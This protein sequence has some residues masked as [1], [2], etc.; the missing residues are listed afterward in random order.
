MNFLSWSPWIGIS[1]KE[2]PANVVKRR[3]RWRR[4][5]KVFGNR[6]INSQTRRNIEAI[7]RIFRVSCWREL[8]YHVN[9]AGVPC[10]WYVDLGKTDPKPIFS[11]Y[12]VGKSS[13]QEFNFL[14]NSGYH[15]SAPFEA[16]LFREPHAGL[17]VDDFSRIQLA[18]D[19]VFVDEHDAL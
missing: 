17:K 16:N 12:Q 9:R 8:K 10:I 2:R 7:E 5:D 4:L 14:S 15:A 18:F 3:L 13:A 19:I 11:K 6:A 1:G